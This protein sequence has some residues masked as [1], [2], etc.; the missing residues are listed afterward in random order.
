MSAKLSNPGYSRPVE[1]R[2][3]VNGMNDPLANTTPQDV[4]FHSV[5]IVGSGLMG[6]GIGIEYAL[7]GASV[8]LVASTPDSTIRAVERTHLELS[9]LAH[10]GAVS[11]DDARAAAARLRGD[12]TLE[13]AAQHAE[14]VV[15]SV[16]EVL[17]T[18][19]AL[20]ERRG[21]ITRP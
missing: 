12:P 11:E 21:E 7:G 6:R 8:V 3:T 17:E 18:K 2:G 13:S 5:T 1:S 15:E 16:P 19:Q 4:S 10:A 9:E 14:L 20:F